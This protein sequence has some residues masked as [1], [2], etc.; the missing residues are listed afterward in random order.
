MKLSRKSFIVLLAILTVLVL[1]VSV[2]AYT[3][4][5]LANYITGTHLISGN[6]Y[7]LADAQAANVKAYLQSNPVTDAQAEQIK[8]L[9][10]QAKSK[11]SG[12]IVLSQMTSAEKAEIISLLQQA[13]AIAGLTVSVDSD[14]NTITV[15]DGRTVL[16]SG[17]Y[18]NAGNGGLTVKFGPVGGS[19]SGAATGSASTT[20]TASNGG[21]K[22]FVYTGAN[23]SVFAVIALLAVVAVSTVFVKKVYAK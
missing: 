8:S 10:E 9:L 21:A 16:L 1:S 2:S 11:V 7:K 13:G 15:S 22:T 19:A 5:D 4:A 18:V 12:D 23:N 6:Q 3:S 17:S 14:A 20:A